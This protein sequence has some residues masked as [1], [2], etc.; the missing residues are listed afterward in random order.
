[1]GK[2]A[3]YD[4]VL[5]LEKNGENNTEKSRDPDSPS[6]EKEVDFFFRTNKQIMHHCVNTY[7]WLY[8]G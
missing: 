1:M 2:H 4:H 3:F 5:A 6:G 8:S 7:Y